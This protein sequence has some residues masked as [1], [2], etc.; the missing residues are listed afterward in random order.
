MEPFKKLIEISNDKTKRGNEKIEQE[1]DKLKSRFFYK[2]YYNKYSHY[3]N[4]SFD[5]DDE[6]T[7]IESN[8]HTKHDL[9]DN[10]NDYILLISNASTSKST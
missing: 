3:S 9:E 1:N 2:N 8:E 5:D 4:K 10:L 7:I 6:K